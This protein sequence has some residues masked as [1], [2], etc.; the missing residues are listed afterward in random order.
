MK[1][2]CWINVLLNREERK[3]GAKVRNEE[4]PLRFS[5]R[6]YHPCGKT[7]PVSHRE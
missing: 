5:S 3:E 2:Y 6:P 7:T 4:I 1:I